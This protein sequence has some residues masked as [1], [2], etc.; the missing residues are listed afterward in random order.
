[1]NRE[2]EVG[3]MGNFLVEKKMLKYNIF[4]LKGKI[5]NCNDLKNGLQKRD[6]LCTTYNKGNY[7]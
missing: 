5:N 2:K 3:F 6:C 4:N 7:I 1:M